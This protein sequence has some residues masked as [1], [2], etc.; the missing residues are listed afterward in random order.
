MFFHIASLGVPPHLELLPERLRLRCRDSSAVRKK[1]IKG[2]KRLQ[3]PRRRA[4]YCYAV[5]VWSECCPFT[6]PDPT[7]VQRRGTMSLR[8]P[9]HEYG[10]EHMPIRLT[11]AY[12]SGGQLS[13]V[14]IGEMKG[15]DFRI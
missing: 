7:D 9:A 2:R 12:A 3:D 8:D 4:E 11:V 6:A 13:L 1:R 15:L 5:H 10:R 14:M